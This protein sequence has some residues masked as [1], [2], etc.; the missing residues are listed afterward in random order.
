M[1]RRLSAIVA[2]LLVIGTASASW[3]ATPAPFPYAPGTTW[4]YRHTQTAKEQTDVGTFTVAYRGLA[5][6]RGASHH[7]FESFSSLVPGLVERD[8]FIWT[9]RYFRQAATA[10]YKDGNILEIIFDKP[11]ALTGAQERLSGTTQIFENG[12]FKA[13][14]KWS[15]AVVP[16][17]SGK[18]TVPAGTYAVEV[19]RGQ[20]AIGAL[21]QRYAVATVGPLEVWAEIDVVVDKTQ[22]HKVKFELQQGP[23]PKG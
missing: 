10:I 6:Y 9:G 2:L 7:Y 23:V 1:I 13:Q 20:L 5:T 15:I 17:G 12:A 4:A 19:W 3:G 14:G 8:Y 21:Q 18:A 16:L 11:Y 22:L